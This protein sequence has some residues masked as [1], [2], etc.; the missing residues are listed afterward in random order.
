[1]APPKHYQMAPP[2][3]Y[4]QDYEYKTST[5]MSTHQPRSSQAPVYQTATMPTTDSYRKPAEN[6]PISMPSA[7]LPSSP[8]ATLP[9]LT[10]TRKKGVYYDDRAIAL[11][12]ESL[13]T[14]S[15]DRRSARLVSFEGDRAVGVSRFRKSSVERD[16]PQ[17]SPQRQR[18][19]SPP[20]SRSPEWPPHGFIPDDDEVLKPIGPP[21]PRSP[22]EI[23]R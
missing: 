18:S 6:R 21:P 13:P 14:G 2:E 23:P 17:R 8:P 1:M 5:Q 3:Q 10:T 16:Q 4:S 12:T 15:L 19:R 9:K 20:I 7:T 22:G 11:S